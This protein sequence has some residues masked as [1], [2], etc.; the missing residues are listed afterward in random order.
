MSEIHLKKALIL[1]QEQITAVRSGD[2]NDD[3]EAY[4]GASPRLHVAVQ[5]LLSTDEAVLD[6]AKRAIDGVWAEFPHLHV[7]LTP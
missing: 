1:M 6:Y 3:W 5:A 7:H 4:G 2:T